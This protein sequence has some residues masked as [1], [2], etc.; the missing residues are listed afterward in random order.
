MTETLDHDV[1]HSAVLERWPKAQKHWSQFLLL[2]EPMHS[3][4]CASIAQIHLGSRQV[5]L[6]Y[7]MIA[8][9]ELGDCIEAL[10]AHEIGHHV[11]YPGT[12]ATEARMRLL[13]KTLIPI[14][15]YSVTNLFT[16]LMINQF[17][18][19]HY[20]DEFVRAY[21]ALVPYEKWERDPAFIFYLSVY[22]ELWGLA[23]GAL[24]QSCS[25]DFAKMYP[26]FRGDARLLADKLFHME[27]NIFTQ[28]LFFVSVLSRYIKPPTFDKPES[29]SPQKCHADEPTPEDWAE[30][31]VPTGRER[32]AIEKAVA[33]GWLSTE[34]AEKLAGKDALQRRIAGLPGMQSGNA[35][36]VPEIM[37]AYYRRE[38]EK[39]LIDPPTE[40]ILGDAIVPTAIEEWQSGDPVNEI[41]WLQTFLNGG[42]EL[43]AA[44]PLKRE[45]IADIEGYEKPIWRPFIEVYLDVSGSMPDPRCT[46]NAMTLASLILI[47]AAVRKGGWA[48]AVLYS[49]DTVEYWSWCRS[50][51]EL[52]GFLMHYFGAGTEFPFWK[53]EESVE[54]CKDKRPIRVVITDHDF[55]QN[56]ATTKQARRILSDAIGN[57]A[58]FF[59]LL[60]NVEPEKSKVY[61]DLGARVEC[62]EDLADYPKMAAKLA[63]ALFES[64]AEHRRE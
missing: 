58:P 8:K 47:T 14:E 31:L 57:S 59:L 4:D 16:D 41:D 22:E 53:L 1:I 30:A 64:D 23:E 60:Y 28:F 37:A 32:A 24:L 2:S 26:G 3:A 63:K 40:K 27:P 44:Q 6:N 12:L 38:A 49:T 61:R 48:R 51:R 62:I 25:R 42:P 50:E 46:V 54:E 18:G 21:Q 10:L 33:E 45:R 36:C 5:R 55:N 29:Q 13:E 39:Y 52:S 15:G 34:D 20:Q 9:H 43:G 11:R 7:Q 17:L 19:E 56:F 35:D